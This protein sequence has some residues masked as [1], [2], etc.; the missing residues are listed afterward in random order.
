MNEWVKVPKL[1]ER[2]D[3]WGHTSTE[4]QRQTRK[5]QNILLNVKI[6]WQIKQ[7]LAKLSMANFFTNKEAQMS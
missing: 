1:P 5:P 6:L 3:F 4:N 2:N 7:A